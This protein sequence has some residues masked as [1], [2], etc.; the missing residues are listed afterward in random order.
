MQN[1]ETNRKRIVKKKKLKKNN[2]FKIAAVLATVAA[3]IGI[4]IGIGLLLGKMKNKKKQ[5]KVVSLLLIMFLSIGI[6]A[7]CGFC[8]FMI[9]IKIEADPKYKNAKLNT[10]EVSR[11]YDCF[12]I[13]R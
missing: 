4:I 8:I 5:R 7:L 13:L 6:V 2:S 10:L 1:K 11:I 3:F 9:Y 12:W